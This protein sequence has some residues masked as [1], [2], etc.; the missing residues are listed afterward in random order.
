[1]QC[2]L[3]ELRWKQNESQ[4]ALALVDPQ[5]FPR[6]QCPLCSQAFHSTDDLQRHGKDDHVPATINNIHYDF[7]AKIPNNKQKYGDYQD[8][9]DLFCLPCDQDFQTLKARENHAKKF[10]ADALADI[11]NEGYSPDLDSF[12]EFH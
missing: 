3:D 8:E 7:Y 1:V 10:H 4:Q 12:E 9:A 11:S 2:V 5:S 6:H